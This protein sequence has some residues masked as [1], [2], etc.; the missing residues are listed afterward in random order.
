MT[1]TRTWTAL[2]AGLTL[3]VASPGSAWAKKKAAQKPAQSA[4]PALP[5]PDKAAPDAD[6]VRVTIQTVPPRKAAVRWGKKSLG[7]IPIPKPLVL[8][9]PR[10]SG[11]MDLVI[12]MAGYLPVHTRAY[13]F[14]DSRVAVKL[15]QVSQKNTLFGYKEEPPVEDA[16]LD[17][18]APATPAGFEPTPTPTATA[19]PTSARKP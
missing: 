5:P 1:K 17:P 13:T 10:D 9:R 15:T 14:S 7:V 16:G 6:T 12:S 19:A 4:G 3:A 11:P 8:V 2:I 18:S